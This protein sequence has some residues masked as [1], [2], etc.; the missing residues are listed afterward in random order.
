MMLM[1]FLA[2]L[3]V[4]SQKRTVFISSTFIEGLQSG[5]QHAVSSYVA[6]QTDG[7]FLDRSD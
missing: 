7:T 1:S 6:L 5:H 4:F 3:V 2:S